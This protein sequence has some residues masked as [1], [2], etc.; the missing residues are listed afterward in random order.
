M[1]ASLVFCVLCTGILVVLCFLA[2]SWRKDRNSPPWRLE[3]SLHLR[4]HDQRLN[5]LEQRTAG[6]EALLVSTVGQETEDFCRA[7]DEIMERM[8][9]E[10]K[11]KPAPKPKEK[12]TLSKEHVG[13]F[14][15]GKGRG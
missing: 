12:L 11:H 9:P 1:D 3:L 10:E 15:K 4:E 14:K 7:M 2:N 13:R 5:E 6:V 8:E